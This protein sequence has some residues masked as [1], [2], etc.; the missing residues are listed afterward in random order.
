MVIHERALV[1]TP[2]ISS[3]G[4]VTYKYKTETDDFQVLYFGISAGAT[5]HKW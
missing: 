4:G 2:T 1:V 3:M 5:K